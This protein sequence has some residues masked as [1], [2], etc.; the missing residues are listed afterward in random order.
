LP[1]AHRLVKLTGVK[2][3]FDTVRVRSF[4]KVALSFAEDAERKMV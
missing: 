3:A 1:K 4:V 2:T